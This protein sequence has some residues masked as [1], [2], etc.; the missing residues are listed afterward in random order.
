MPYVAAPPLKLAVNRKFGLKAWNKI[1]DVENDTL[2]ACQVDFAFGFF[3]FF[4]SLISC[5]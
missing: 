3:T 5:G 4:S 1:N 2:G